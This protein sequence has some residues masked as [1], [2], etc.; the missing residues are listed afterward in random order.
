[1]AALLKTYSS[2]RLSALL[3]LLVVSFAARADDSNFE[4][5]GHTKLNAT[6]L[7]FPDDSALHALF[8]SSSLDAQADAR[9]N[10]KWRN[11][12]WRF[13]ADYQLVGLHGEYI[14]LGAEL[15]NDNRR[16][17]NLTDV[18]S[19]SGDNALLHRLDRLWLGYSTEKTVV[20]IGR[21]AL[22]WG[23]GLFYAPMDLVN[24][25]DPA[26]IDTEYKAGDDMLY[27]QYLRDSGDDIQGAAVIRRNAL[28]GDVE[29]GV[30][31]Y[32][33]KY[34]GFAGEFEYDVLIADS[35]ADAVLGLGW[36]RGIGG[37]YW[38]SDLVI[39][40]TDSDSYVQFVTNLSYS[41]MFKGK[42]MSGALEYHYNG[43][44]Q[45]DSRYDPLSLAEN[46]EL[47]SRIARGQ[48]FTLGRHYLA[49]S[50]MIEMTP[51]WSITPV[52]LANVGDSSALLQLTTNYSLGDNMIL[53]GSINLP[54][55]S[56]GTEFGGIES[57]QPGLYLS[58]GPSVFAQFAWYF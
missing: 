3:I 22:S 17:F 33:V 10:V 5:T 58:T 23:N 45:S 7:T 46:P 35:Y 34:H 42:N 13:D 12:G 39:T 27:A 18:I 44:G 19:E 26:T 8:G 31:S 9:L 16:L 36:G 56:S 32:A 1:M 6:G 21:Q 47:L 55:G 52:L 2:M 11:N 38:G 29:S 48:M 15:P 53:L 4:F 14:G 28:S 25:F 37:A 30:G 41:W 24:P 40:D 43:F 49:G 54:M 20:R 50:V 57:G 51:L